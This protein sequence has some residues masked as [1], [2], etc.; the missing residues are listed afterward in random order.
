MST[1]IRKATP[2]DVPSIY[3]LIVELAEYEKALHEVINTPEQLL[4]DG[5][6]ENPLFGTIIAEVK[7]EVVG[8]SLYYYRYST[9]KGKRLYLEDL[10]IKEA[11]RGYGLGKRLLEA[12]VEEARQTECSGLMWQVLD[13]NEP[14][15]EFYK[16]FGA[17]LDEEWINCHFDL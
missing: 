11:F 1:I 2:E 3:Q 4:K 10:I 7:G 5:F 6:G 12:T 9:W 17:K 15:I 13:W 14:S 8:M 16:K